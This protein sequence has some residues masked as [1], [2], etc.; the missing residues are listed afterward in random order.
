MRA[1]GDMRADGG[2]VEDG[3]AEVLT[4]EFNPRRVV[5]PQQ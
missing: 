3:K 2:S 1:S 5:F 4:D